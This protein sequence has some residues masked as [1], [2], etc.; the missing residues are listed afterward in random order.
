MMDFRSRKG[1]IWI[2][3]RKKKAQHCYQ[4]K[5]KMKCGSRCPIFLADRCTEK[6]EVTRIKKKVDKIRTNF[7]DKITL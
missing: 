2:D 7:R 4:A 1:F 6:E 3:K 5:A